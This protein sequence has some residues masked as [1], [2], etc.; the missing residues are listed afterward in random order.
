MKKFAVS[1][2][3][4]CFS[5]TA[6][7]AYHPIEEIE[8]TASGNT[9]LFE[10][11]AES[12]SA[13]DAGQLL[14]KLPG[15]NTNSNG[16]L[17]SVA[18]FRGMFG[19]RINVAVDGM[20]MTGGGP[21]AMDS[22]LSY[23]PGAMLESIRVYRGIAPVSAAQQAVGGAFEAQTRQ[24]EFADSARWQFHGDTLLATGSNNNATTVYTH[25][26]A[27]NDQHKLRI[28][29]LDERADDTEFP[30]GKIIPTE[31][32][33]QRYELGYAYRQGFH[34]ASIDIIRND[35]GDSGTPALPMDIAYID[36]D[37]VRLAWQWQ[38]TDRAFDLRWQYSDIE[39]EMTNY[40]LRQPP[41]NTMMYRSTRATASVHDIKAVYEQRQ[42]NLLWRVGADL[43]DAGH[44]AVV[45]NPEN[46]MFQ[47]NNFNDVENRIY[48]VFAESEYRLDQRNRL[49]A[50]LRFNRVA[51]DAG[52]VAASGM[53]GMM[54]T[55]A[56]TLSA[57]FNNSKTR[58]TDNNL[59]AVLK[60][61]HQ[62][63][64]HW[65]LSAEA[66]QKMRS[67]SYQERYLWMPMQSTGGLADGFTYI[68]NTELKPET[69]HELNLGLEWNNGRSA[70]APRV[71]YREVSDYIQG[72]PVT[73]GQDP[74]TDAAIAL[75]NMMPGGADPLQFSNVDATLT[76]VDIDWHSRL[77]PQMTL[78][79]VVSIVRGERD[80]I[81]DYLYRIAPD[82]ASVAIDYQQQKLLSTFEVVAYDRQSRVS[83]TNNEQETA[84]YIQVNLGF[85][86]QASD[87]LNLKLMIDNLFDREFANHLNGINRADGSD[88]AVGERLPEMGRNIHASLRWTF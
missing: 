14:R 86:Y 2:V 5:A 69:A 67:P 55:H 13:P 50:G 59:D 58:Q 23:A 45:S 1:F 40:H 83:E 32:E 78:R 47:V 31:Y 57:A 22:P 17:S 80:D 54:A 29:G 65:K 15:A 53:M 42:L 41:G 60:W 20:S 51:M 76:G 82:H 12:L 4:L 70:I 44:D 46:S 79:G 7:Q 16:P 18:Q 63:A 71:F 75:A 35:T 72:T 49:D 62:L 34:T 6:A 61:H 66:G 56:N 36:T 10:V 85:Q 81:D 74:I 30:S 9:G 37:I 38:Q 52:D 28:A 88:V 21:N 26:Y 27:A 19:S 48:G 77:N 68:G 39:H 33:R 84:G 87:E 24:G 73:Q 25:V 11:D 3:V 43:H 8:I 64:D